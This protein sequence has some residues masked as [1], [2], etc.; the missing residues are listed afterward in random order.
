MI[1]K[2][3]EI[4]KGYGLNSIA[5]RFPLLGVFVIGLSLSL[6]SFLLYQNERLNLEQSISRE[7]IGIAVTGTLLIDPD[8]HEDIYSLNQ[9]E[10]EKQ[11][12]FNQL[13][14]ILLK[15]QKENNLKKSVYTLR[16]AQD[17]EKSHDM[18]FVVMTDLGPDGKPYTGNHIKMTDYV[19]KVYQ[20]GQPVTTSLY[21]DTEGTWLS[22]IAPIKDTD[23]NVVAVLSIDQDVYFYNDALRQAQKTIIIAAV[24]ALLS[25]GFFFFFLTQPIIKRIRMLIE[26]TKKISYGDLSH[27]IA[28]QGNDELESL[29][30]AFNEM[31]KRLSDTIKAAEAAHI[32][33]TENLE[34]KIEE[35]TF[36]LKQAHKQLEKSAYYSGMAEIARG[37]LHDINNTLQGLKSNLSNI[38]SSIKNI[39]P[40]YFINI[41]EYLKKLKQADEK[42][43]EVLSFFDKANE[44]FSKNREEAFRSL[45]ECEKIVNQIGKITSA[46]QRHAKATTTKELLDINAVLL[47]TINMY[48]TILDN[49]KIKL[50]LKLADNIPNLFLNEGELERLFG[51]I[52]KNAIDAMEEIARDDHK[53]LIESGIKSTSIDVKITDTGVGIKEKDLPNI[54][55]SDFTTKATGIGIGLSFCLDFMKRNDG[56]IFVKS[57]EGQGTEFLLVFMINK[58]Q[59]G[60]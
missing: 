49:K 36:E 27:E 18:E 26:G 6:I 40:N 41:L 12:T 32:E 45:F 4:I 34:K 28:I 51:N 14:D 11:E 21:T 52:V 43:A 42:W 19:Q 53:L 5:V 46:Q 60:L 59:E 44:L 55:R 2:K 24:F 56:K 9:G 47:N 22:A 13:K 37:I 35:R 29:A 54:F 33:Y 57:I 39:D 20:T 17:F 23:G 3:D 50:E 1:L 30:T 16:K 25:G 15:I 31:T 8:A 7:L 10:I 48:K 38:D 58:N